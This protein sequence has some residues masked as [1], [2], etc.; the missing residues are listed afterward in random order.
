VAASGR[1]RT[2]K[3]GRNTSVDRMLTSVRTSFG[4]GQQ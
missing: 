2:V 3:L 4:R 1:R